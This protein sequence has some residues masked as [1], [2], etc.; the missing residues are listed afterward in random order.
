M[1][2]AD[3]VSAG[4]LPRLWARR[5][6]N[7]PGALL[8]QGDATG[9]SAP[10]GGRHRSGWCTA[11]EFDEATRRVAGR[12]VGVGLLPGERLVW[13]TSSSVPAL[14]A[15]VAALRA[16]LVVVPANPAYTERELAHIVAD[17]RPA[18]AVVERPEQAEWVRR[19]SAGPVVVVGT[20]VD[21][22]DADPGSLDT[23]GP[24]DP[25]LV[26][27]TSGTTGLAKGA[28]LRH[29]NLLAAAESV[30]VAWR[31]TADDRL[32]HCLPLFHAHGLC[33]A[34]YGT[35]SSGASAVLLPGFDPAAVVDAIRVEGASL[36]FGVPTMYHRLA[37]S[38]RAG[39]LRGLRLAVSG[40]A[41]LA[42]GLHAEVSAAM[43]SA[44]LERYGL[45][46]TL[47]NVSHPYDGD[48]RAGTVGFPLPGVEVTL[49]TADEIL[50]RGPNVFA[51]YWERPAADAE[52]FV[53]DRDGGPAWFRTGD[54]GA[55]DQG[56]LRVRGRI[57]EL[58]ISGGYNVYPGE[59]EDV[60]LGHPRVAEVAVT[61][62][63]S[64]EWGEVVTAWVV[65]DGTP[66][67][68]D[69]LVE[70]TAVSLAPYKRPRRVHLVDSLP[71]NALGKVVRSQLGP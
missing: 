68:T 57:K 1:D 63:Q 69:E 64:D 62:T 42:A 31:W 19:A 49:G 28:V 6:R 47:M 67:S 11:G 54:V 32:V 3:L 48:R 12:L 27:Y 37:R 35:L 9:R 29:R 18:A 8:W 30:R 51:G 16:G 5:W 52:A 66:P 34:V 14:V 70:F 56:D 45:T 24:D 40:S 15:H 25:A 13:A 22:P 50:V 4:T 38:G 20:E 46:E 36:F 58:I 26:C 2:A 65:P 33:V 44:V 71:R 7:D 61:G 59:V 55:E 41:P 21:L 53:A 60:L 17:V 23:S 43:G 39:G 10:P